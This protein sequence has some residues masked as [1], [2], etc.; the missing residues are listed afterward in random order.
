[1]STRL[2]EIKSS[3]ILR[4]WGNITCPWPFKIAV[5]IVMIAFSVIV[6]WLLEGE[7]RYI[8]RLLCRV[9]VDQEHFLM[10]HQVIWGFDFSEVQPMLTRVWATFHLPQPGRLSIFPMQISH[11]WG[12]EGCYC[13]I[14]RGKQCCCRCCEFSKF[15]AHKADDLVALDEIADEEQNGHVLPPPIS[16]IICVWTLNIGMYNIG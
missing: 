3:L 7:C 11:I 1:M 10:Q 12:F 2:V 14:R 5:S 13:G 9:Q 8:Y 15:G 4:W 16:W 6:I